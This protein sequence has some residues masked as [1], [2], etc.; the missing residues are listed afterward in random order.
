MKTNTE[1]KPGFFYRTKDDH[2]S[3]LTPGFTF[4]IISNQ[5]A[6]VMDSKVFDHIWKYRGIN[7]F[8]TEVKGENIVFTG[9]FIAT[10][11]SWFQR[12][13]GKFLNK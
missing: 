11:K 1:I 5:E 2:E 10:K 4:R 7:I 8:K 6:N 13:K 12:L 3:E 9:S